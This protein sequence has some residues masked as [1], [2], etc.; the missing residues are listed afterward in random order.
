MSEA[1]IITEAEDGPPQLFLQAPEALRSWWPQVRQR[2]VDI[3][4]ACEEPWSAEDVYDALREK[5]A[6]LWGTHD[7][8]GFIVIELPV[9][10]H[11]RELHC[12]IVANG[13]DTPPSGFWQQIVR[14]GTECGC[15]RI[16][17]ENDRAGFQRHIPGLR[18]RYKYVFEL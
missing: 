8:S 6:F 5:T 3:A 4:A 11:G 14:M 17:F 2:I 16:T 12:W 13:T 1:E 9:Q 10:P 7:L 18:L 15:C